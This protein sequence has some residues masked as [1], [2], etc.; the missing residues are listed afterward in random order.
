MTWPRAFVLELRWRGVEFE[1]VLQA[2]EHTA[3]IACRVAL[4]RLSNRAVQD[5]W[6]RSDSDYYVRLDSDYYV[7]LDSSLS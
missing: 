6:M 4:G 1:S 2:N 3:Q 7:R 5:H